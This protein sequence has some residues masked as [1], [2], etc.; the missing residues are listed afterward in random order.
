LTPVAP[1]IRRIRLDCS[2]TARG[3]WRA[4]D[5]LV[6]PPSYGTPIRPMSAAASS[7]ACGVRKNVAMPV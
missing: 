6:T 7:S 2:R 3:P 4:P 5:R 1:F